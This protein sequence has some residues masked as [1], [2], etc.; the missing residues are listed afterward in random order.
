MGA[1][2]ELHGGRLLLGG[3]RNVKS[4]NVKSLS[5][6]WSASFTQSQGSLRPKCP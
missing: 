6:Q 2:N 1:S 3:A 5:H 4:R